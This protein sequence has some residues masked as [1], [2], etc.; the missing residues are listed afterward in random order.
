MKEVVLYKNNSKIILYIISNFSLNLNED[1]LRVKSYENVR[2]ILFYDREIKEY[3]EK[4]I[5]SY[6][7]NC[8]I[9]LLNSEIINHQVKTN[10]SVITY[11]I[12]KLSTVTVSSI[13]SEV[14]DNIVVCVQRKFKT[15]FGNVVEPMEKMFYNKSIKIPSKVGLF[16]LYS[17][18]ELK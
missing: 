1:I 8:D 11:G 5:L 2:K 9:I 7:K 14:E 6:I 16:C 12:D 4:K 10:A 17:I 15:L 18:L 3:E 13:S